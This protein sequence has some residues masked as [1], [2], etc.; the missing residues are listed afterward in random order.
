MSFKIEADVTREDDMEKFR[1]LLSQMDPETEYI[2]FQASPEVTYYFQ[3]AGPETVPG[4]RS[5]N[6]ILQ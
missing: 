1:H 3:E 5:I 4:P 6:Q 2:V